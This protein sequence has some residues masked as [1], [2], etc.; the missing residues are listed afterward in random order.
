M[1]VSEWYSKSKRSSDG[2]M[3][4][5]SSSPWSITYCAETQDIFLWKNG[6]RLKLVDDGVSRS[7]G[8]VRN[9]CSIEEVPG[10]LLV[11]Q[12]VL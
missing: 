8:S 11:S 7:A 10:A 6:E 4:S 2:G 9:V 3:K 12:L 5:I 1:S